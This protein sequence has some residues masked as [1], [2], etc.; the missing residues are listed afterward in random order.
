MIQQSFKIN[1]YKD[2]IKL[3]ESKIIVRLSNSNRIIDLGN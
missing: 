2:L 3:C 1:I